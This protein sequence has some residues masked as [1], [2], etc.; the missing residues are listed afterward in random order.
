MASADWYFDFVSPFSYLQCEQLAALETRIRIRYRPVL[1]AGLLK[2]HG[3]KGPAEIPSKRRFTYRFVLWRA[4]KLGLPFRMPPAHPFNPLA[5]LR[6]VI[7]AGSDLRA[8][9]TVLQAAFGEGRD[10]TDS[11]VIAELAAQLGVPDPE[12]AL[13]EPAVKQRLRANTLWASSQGVFGVPTLVIGAELF[14]GHDAVDM[15]LDYLAHPQGFADAEMRRSE[16]LPI[17]AARAVTR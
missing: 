14:W 2:A 5:A 13:A 7:A 4:R 15:A 9:G 8:A 16:S 6:L 10:L 12:R 1:F 3:H 11:G 17:G